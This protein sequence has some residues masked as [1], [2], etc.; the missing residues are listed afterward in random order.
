MGCSNSTAVID[1]KL[2]SYASRST[3]TTPSGSL[4]F[5]TPSGSP[6]MSTRLSGSEVRSLSELST[7]SSQEI[8]ALHKFFRKHGTK[9]EHSLLITPSDWAV[10]LKPYTSRTVFER[11]FYLFDKDH[12]GFVDF[13]EFVTALSWLTPGA[14]LDD[15][16]L[17]CFRFY[18]LDDSNRIERKDIET[19][20]LETLS[21]S[22]GLIPGVKLQFTKQQLDCLVDRTLKEADC[23]GDGVI[24]FRDFF[25]FAQ[26]SPAFVR[27]LC[28]HIE[29]VRRCLRLPASEADAKKIASPILKFLTPRQQRM[30]FVDYVDEMCSDA[31]PKQP[32]KQEKVS[33]F[34]HRFLVR[35]NSDTIQLMCD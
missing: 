10:L 15:Q 30:S 35:E 20:L 3:S 22:E 27:R 28:L 31:P 12:D 9:T 7:F 21:M 1:G 2:T 6:K 18:D 4:F 19:L 13:S 25:T 11:L 24:N 17:F 8:I 34:I 33:R 32:N 16:I 5:G 23:D 29:D 26:K 14:S